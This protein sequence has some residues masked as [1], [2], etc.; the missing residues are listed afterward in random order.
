VRF[1]KGDRITG[2]R[3]G[4]TANGTVSGI[5]DEKEFTQ[6]EERTVFVRW[7]GTTFTEDEM[8]VSEVKPE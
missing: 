2:G 1:K 7:D 8:G 4:W 6:G 5:R 3:A